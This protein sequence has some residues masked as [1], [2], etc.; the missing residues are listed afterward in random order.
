[1][2]YVKLRRP[3][4]QES[5][6]NSY[7]KCCLDVEKYIQRIRGSHWGKKTPIDISEGKM[8]KVTDDEITPRVYIN[9]KCSIIWK[10]IPD[11]SKCLF[12]CH[13]PKNHTG[14]RR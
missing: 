2:I 11:T 4:V 8:I 9:R 14:L 13:I 7:L 5:W 3:C 10:I 6:V 1:L 12:G